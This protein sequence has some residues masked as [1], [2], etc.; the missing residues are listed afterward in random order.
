[1]ETKIVTIL[2][3]DLL[4]LF[5]AISFIVDAYKKDN[6]VT[7]VLG[8]LLLVGFILSIYPFVRYMSSNGAVDPNPIVF[9]VNN[10]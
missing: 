5:F 9:W 4:I 6:I 3:F 7:L 2:I 1:M 10:L 8:F